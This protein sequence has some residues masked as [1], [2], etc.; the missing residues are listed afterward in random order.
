LNSITQLCYNISM[1]RRRRDVNDQGEVYCRSCDRWRH[2]SLYRTQ[3]VLEG[4]TPFADV[5]YEEGGKL[6]GRPDGYCKA[7]ASAKS[8]G[9]EKF[10]VYLGKIRLEQSDEY[11]AK[12]LKEWKPMGPPRSEP[13]HDV[14]KP[15]LGK[16]P[17]FETDEEYDAYWTP[18]RIAYE[19]AR[20]ELLAEETRKGL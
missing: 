14:H 15:E 4:I 7:C 16:L 5:W 3:E 8:Q 17:T 2:L 18:A 20:I 1:G 13:K 6:Y 9:R 19:S 11:K 10:D 12:V